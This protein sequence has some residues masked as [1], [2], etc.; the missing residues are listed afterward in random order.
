MN[1]KHTNG[2]KYTHKLLYKGNLASTQIVRALK[3]PFVVASQ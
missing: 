1:T 2:R 3:R